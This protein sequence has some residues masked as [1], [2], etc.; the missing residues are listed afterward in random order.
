VNKTKGFTL[1]EMAIVLVIIGILLGVV[2]LRSG[3]VIGNAKTT[4]TI[5]LIKDLSAATNDFMNRYHYLPGDLPKAGDDIPGI[6]GT[7]CDIAT[8]TANIGNGQI[9]T[10]TEVTCAAV[11]LV[12]AGLIKGSTDGIFSP[13][14]A[15]NTP[16]VFIT[17]RRT[18]GSNLPTFPST[19]LNEIEL[20]NQPCATAQGIDSKL[21]DG[22]FASGKIQA[23]VTSCSPGVTNDPVPYLDIAL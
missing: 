8:T 13:N 19:V 9:D 21:D 16:D 23:S 12:Q 15:S 11:E 5:A 3:S 18:I 4:G 2:L 17:A 10:N 14:N 20:T 6:T 7:T 1:I 22:N